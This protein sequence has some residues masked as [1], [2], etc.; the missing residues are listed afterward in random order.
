MI[1]FENLK[2]P[3]FTSHL[4]SDTNVKFYFEIN[5]EN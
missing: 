1:H 4:Q 2:F 5:V 3:F